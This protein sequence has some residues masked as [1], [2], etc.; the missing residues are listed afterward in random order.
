MVRRWLLA[1]IVISLIFTISYSQ[2]I[3]SL[4][5]T[6][7]NDLEVI[8]STAQN[9]ILNNVQNCQ[10]NKG[11]P[12]I[13]TVGNY[14][15]SGFILDPNYGSNLINSNRLVYQPFSTNNVTL[16]NACASMAI[17]EI[18][19][20]QVKNTAN[21]T[22]RYITFLNGD[23]ASC[24]ADKWNSSYGC[25]SSIDFRNSPWVADTI[26]SPTIFVLTI[27]TSLTSDLS[28]TKSSVINFLN[29][30][31]FWH[32][33]SIITYSPEFVLIP[34]MRATRE[35][36]QIMIEKVNNLTTTDY[37]FDLY[38]V[39][40]RADAI[41]DRT[42][43]IHPD[44]AIVL[45]YSG[46]Q[47]SNV[48]PLNQALSGDV[49]TF[50]VLIS[51]NSSLTVPKFLACQTKGIFIKTYD[52]E[53]IDNIFSAL[54]SKIFISSNSAEIISS[55]LV[56]RLSQIYNDS[57]TEKSTVTFSYP[58]Y[59]IYE[60]SVYLPIGVI[61]IDVK[62]D[63]IRPTNFTNE[64]I[65]NYILQNQTY[66]NDPIGDRVISLYSGDVCSVPSG[67]QQTTWIQLYGL[68]V[69]LTLLLIL[70]PTIIIV[71]MCIKCETSIVYFTISLILLGLSIIGIGLVFGISWGEYVRSETWLKQ[72]F[73]TV[74][75][76]DNPYRC[77]EIQNC[78]CD[79]TSAPSCSSMLN[80]LQAGE[81]GSGYYCCHRRCSTS[82]T[83]RTCTTYCYCSN[84]VSNQRCNI[85][86]GTCHNPT[87]TFSYLNNVLDRQINTTKTQSCSR[88]N[89][90]CVTS[91]YSQFS[92][93]GQ[94][95]I[96][97]YD[98]QNSQ[99]FVF[100]LDINIAAFVCGVIIYSLCVIGNII[101]MIL[102]CIQHF[103]GRPP[104]WG[105]NSF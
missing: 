59:K 73:Y 101:F 74:K 70:I 96:G 81:C 48:I 46:D 16:L 87:V 10:F 23:L 25:P 9:S 5:T 99:G 88:D 102:N 64:D 1:F 33:I 41:F 71:I 42:S 97:Y 14:N 52:G 37:S 86:C 15:N 55:S 13:P 35:N 103:S 54:G 92:P 91:Y 56:L 27:Q 75:H 104:I 7:I 30:C 66:N 40:T 6:F 49:K 69:T 17:Q 11:C 105:K 57:L 51:Q 32:F 22:Y 4:S 72:D 53:G 80:N 62:T 77:C 26:I 31:G 29:R 36:I 3:D 89:Y 24:P 60:T 94:N 85:V 43:D 34:L 45:F 12:N 93:I 2:T 78:Y 8:R 47:G 82:C 44:F 21:S 68:W 50:S 20:D 83:R 76:D 84:S 79:E 58:L 63:A 28:A 61:S 98:P 90:G 19:I 100:N 65:I 38:S 95:Q 39:L 67:Y 18:S